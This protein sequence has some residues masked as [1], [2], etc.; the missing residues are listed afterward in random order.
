M[1]Q[2]PLSPPIAA[3]AAKGH[4]YMCGHCGVYYTHVLRVKSDQLKHGVAKP[5]DM[6]V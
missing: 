5:C 2:T 3:G 6:Y 4:M 1:I